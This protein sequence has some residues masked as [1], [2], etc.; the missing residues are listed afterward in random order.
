[1]YLVSLA[2]VV[3]LIVRPSLRRPPGRDRLLMGG[4]GINLALVLATFV[5]PQYGQFLLSDP[6][7]G[8]LVGLIAAIVAFAAA[9][10]RATSRY[11]DSAI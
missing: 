2:M 1:M 10:A 5:K 8:Y 4:T 7:S 11:A 6:Y 9:S 3:Y